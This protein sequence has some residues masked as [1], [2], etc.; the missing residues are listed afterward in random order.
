MK[1]C[2]IHNDGDTVR[3]ALAAAQ[4]YADA[5]GYTYDGEH[6][7][8]I[9]AEGK[10]HVYF[11]YQGRRFF[12]VSCE[13]D[14]TAPGLMNP[15]GAIE[16]HVSSADEVARIIRQRS[17]VDLRS[18]KFSRYYLHDGAIVVYLFDNEIVIQWFGVNKEGLLPADVTKHV[19][20]ILGLLKSVITPR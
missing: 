2:A 20:S 9:D 6:Y 1:T 4:Q 10:A 7:S 14:F 11:G 5:H 13:E 15:M 16:V 8:V 3:E 18:E 12:T 19:A 17:S